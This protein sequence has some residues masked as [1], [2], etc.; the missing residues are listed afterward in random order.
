MY[1]YVEFL[2]LRLAV[3]ALHNQVLKTFYTV[4][5]ILIVL[6]TTIQ[7]LDIIVCK[8]TICFFMHTIIVLDDY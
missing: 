7:V 4:Q 1:M 8:L 5:S 3:V 2:K 6:E